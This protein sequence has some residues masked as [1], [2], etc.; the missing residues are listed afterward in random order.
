[1][2]RYFVILNGANGNLVPMTEGDDD[3][4]A[5]YDTLVEAQTAAEQLPIACAWGY[6]VFD[7]DNPADY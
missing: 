2:K 3:R 7:R 1:M 5:T 6:N 4:L